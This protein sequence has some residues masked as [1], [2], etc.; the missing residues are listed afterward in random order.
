M[1]IY[2][3]Y[4]KTHIET[5]LKYL[6]ETVAK[7][8]HQYPGSGTYWKKH[9][10]KHGYN[11]TTEIIKECRSKEEIKEWGLYYSNLWNVVESSEWANLKPETGPGGGYLKG[12]R[13]VTEETK[14]KLSIAGKKKPPMTEETKSKISKSNTGKK[15][16]EESRKKMSQRQVGRSHTPET[17]EKIKI[18]R[19]SQVCSKR[20]EETKA[21]MSAAQ[22]GRTLTE[23]HKQKLRGRTFTE[24]HKQ[25]LRGRAFTE[26]HKQKLSQAAKARKYKMD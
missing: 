1:T 19:A 4:V 10:E 21:K 22:K 18:A 2:K 20:S 16:S 6:G 13:I 15:R 25:K 23:E 12:T 17:K 5:G 3:L 26:E 24:E 11:Y 9:L 8:P 7:D 14:R